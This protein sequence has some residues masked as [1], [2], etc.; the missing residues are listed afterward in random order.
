[1]EIIVCIKQ[2]IDPESKLNIDPSTGLIEQ[3]GL[4]YVLNPNDEFAVEEALRIRDKLGQGRVTVLTLGPPRARDTLVRCL[5]MGVD[6]V[7]LIWDEA[8]EGCDVHVTSLVLARAIGLLKY[9]LI[10]IGCEAWDDGQGYVGA[11]VAKELEIPLITRV[12]RAELSPD[13]GK[14]TALRHLERGD[15]ARVE[16]LLPAGFAIAMRTNRPRYPKLRHRLLAPKRE[17]STWD[18][19]TIGL[20]EDKV[21]CL[22]RLEEV[23]YPRPRAKKVATPD[24]SLSPMER[25][26]FFLTGGVTERAANLLD[27]STPEAVSKVTEFLIEAGI[28]QREV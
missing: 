5:A 20:G 13:G 1:M 3:R 19:K 25:L 4:S 14:A 9:G 16:C 17:L 24:S 11:G 7:V 12:C 8:L 27:G 22:M 2:V 26:S 18:L 10:L 23:S 28:I 15:Q 6:E 21:G